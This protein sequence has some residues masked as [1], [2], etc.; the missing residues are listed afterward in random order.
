MH[1]Y[2]PL[3][4]C[5]MNFLCMMSYFYILMLYDNLKMMKLF[6]FK[7]HF[8]KRLG[9]GEE[10]KKRDSYFVYI[11]SRTISTFWEHLGPKSAYHSIITKSFCEHLAIASIKMNATGVLVELGVKYNEEEYKWTIYKDK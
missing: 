11:I 7:G 2:R 10:G 4:R 9:S 5:Q 1:R 8:S 6:F 3:F